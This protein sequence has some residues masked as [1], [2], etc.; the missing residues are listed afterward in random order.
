MENLVQKTTCPII[1]KCENLAIERL[2]ECGSMYDANFSDRH[3]RN[4]KLCNH[5]RTLFGLE[6]KQ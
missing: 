2:E 6:V 4:Y 3:C 5:Y 1:Q